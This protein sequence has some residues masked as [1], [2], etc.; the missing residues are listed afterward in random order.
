MENIIEVNNLVKRYGDVVA[1]SDISFT[2]QKS[3]LFAL[4]G[5]N[6]AGKST[7]INVLSTMLKKD[8][9][10]V[11]VNGYDLDREYS[12]IKRD[13]GI[14]FQGSVLDGKLSVL[15]NLTTR[16]SYYGLHGKI[17]K[18]RLDEVTELFDLRDL[19]KRPYEKLSGGQ[20]RRVDIARA[21]VNR[22]KIL[23][24]D[25]PTT[26]LDPKTRIMVWDII[27]KLRQDTNLTVFLTTHYMEET[28]DADK[29]VILD[30]G[31]IVACDTP[32][33]LKNR[34]T[35]DYVKIYAENNEENDRWLKSL[36]LDFEYSVNSYR[37]RFSK[38][39]SAREFIKNNI[40]NLSDFELVKGDMDDVFLN[41]TGKKLENV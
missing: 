27:K 32:N 5:V 24:L 14:V 21:L 30:D 10:T 34:F 33:S 18:E 12:G 16:A 40:D 2:V 23:F 7:T 22:P 41:V 38:F 39:S 37:V 26:G 19:L 36:K 1:V 3:S 6:G 31:K 8:G 29:V 9:G 35:R 28:V 25:E 15:D 17:L 13:I 20:R 11:T 4:L